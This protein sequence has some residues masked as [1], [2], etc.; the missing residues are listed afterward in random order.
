M[1]YDAKNLNV[2][3]TLQSWKALK[4]MAIQEDK[5]IKEIVADVIETGIANHKEK[6]KT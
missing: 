3:I 2:E 6:K 4:I 5:S 1:K